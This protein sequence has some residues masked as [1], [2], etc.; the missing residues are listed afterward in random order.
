MYNTL[1]CVIFVLVDV[2]VVVVVVGGGG[3]IYQFSSSFPVVHYQF[4]SSAYL[5]H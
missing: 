2:V 4:Y 1:H 3:D 5:M